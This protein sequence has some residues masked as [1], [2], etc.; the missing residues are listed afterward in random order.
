MPSVS[1]AATASAS[2]T[3]YPPHPPKR[4]PLLGDVLGL[5]PV[6]PMQKTAR[7][8]AQL[9]PIYQRRILGLRLTFVGGAALAAEVNDDAV[10]R[11]AVAR[12]LQKLR[13]IVADGLFTAYDDEPNWA[14]AHAILAPAFTQASMR[15]Y[16]DTMLGVVDEMCTAWDDTPGEL[17]VAAEMTKLT[18]ET[19]GRCGFGY[20]FGSFDSGELDPFV[21]AMSSALGYVQKQGIPV[22]GRTLYDRVTGRAREHRRDIDHMFTVVDD[23][24]ADRRSAPHQ[25]PRD[26]LDLMLA[27]A[28]PD[29]GERLDPV[30]VRNQILTFLVAGHETS[31][32]ALAFALYLL[33][34]HPGEEEKARGEVDALWAGVPTVGFEQVAKL[35]TVRRVLD[36]TLRLWPTA[37]GYFREAKHDTVLG[38]RYPIRAGQMVMVVLQGVHT[39]PAVWGEDA[40]EFRPDRFLPEEVRAR[41]GHAYKPFGTGIRACIGRQFAYH[42]MILALATILHRYRITIDSAPTLDVREQLTFKPTGLR[43]TVTRR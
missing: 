15:S 36:E 3:S 28:D 25:D 9:G 31:S 22:P 41:P 2:R 42:E 1:G 14:K 11:K 19:I 34:S 17:D 32:S 7:M 4:V 21:Q 30:N 35:R 43:M 12:P 37:P 23:V 16:H 26:L 5:D 6:K 40:D 29:T 8:L 39:D 27:T 18:L 38:G 10:W 33:S 20:R 13:P 24:I